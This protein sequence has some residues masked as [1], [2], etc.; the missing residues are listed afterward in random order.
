MAFG[1]RL[2]LKV[3]VICLKMLLGVTLRCCSL[4]GDEFDAIDAALRLPDYPDVWT[5]GGRV[6]DEVCGAS[7]SGSGFYAPL[8]GQRWS[9]LNDIGPAG[10]VVESCRG[11]CSVP[12]PFQTV[13]TAEFWVVVLALQ[14][15]AAVHL[16]VDNLNGV[17]YVGRL[18]DGCRSSFPAEKLNDGDLIMLIDR[19]LE[20]RGRNTVR[21]TFLNEL[22]ILFRC[23]PRSATAL[24]DGVLPLWYCA[25][26][27]ASRNAVLP[28]TC[29]TESS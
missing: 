12:G 2:L 17:R 1:Q 23:P 10:G 26:R 16:G 4:S 15:S 8:P 29:K 28:F 18:L 5:G 9:H 27:F 3:L 19:V 21:V 13:Q 20:Q 11:F 22:L 24:L 7:P 14:A 6:L 25:A